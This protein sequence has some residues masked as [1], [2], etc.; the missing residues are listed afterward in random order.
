M[1]YGAPPPQQYAQHAPPPPPPGYGPPMPPGQPVIIDVGATATKQLVVGSIVLGAIGGIALVSGLI[2]AVDGGSGGAIAA[3]A[4]GAVFL[5]LG[6]LPVLMRKKAFR[7]RKLIF[8]P[9]GLRWDDPQ[10]RPWAVGWNELAAVSISKHGKLEIKQE[11]LND[12]IVGAATDKL[13]GENVLIRLDLY[14]SDRGF[15]ARHPQ[16]EHLWEMHDVKNGYRLPL[17][18]NATYVQPIAHALARFAPQIYR[19]VHTT[20]GF[21]GLT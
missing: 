4:I 16:M 18:R 15:R 21:M 1:P 2:G 14:P 10:G 11:S 8:E 13:T 17:G 12:K 3:V 6:L 7:P 19:G 20:E 9:A 5:L